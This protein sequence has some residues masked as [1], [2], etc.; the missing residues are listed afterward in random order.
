MS[1]YFVHLYLKR[2]HCL[3]KLSHRIPYLPYMRVVFLL[4]CVLI[5][6][7]AIAQPKDT[8]HCDC[9][10]A[11]NIPIYKK[12]HHIAPKGYGAIIEFERNGMHNG[13]YFDKEHNTVWYSFTVPNEG[14]L[15]FD[16]I[17]DTVKDDY[18]FILF[19][20]WGPGACDS[21]KSKKLVPVRANISHNGPGTKSLTGMSAAGRFDYNPPGA[22]DNYSKALKVNSGER[23]ILVVDNVY[24]NGKGHTLKFYFDFKLRGIVQDSSSGKPLTATI[25]LK[26]LK[27]GN[28]MTKTKCDSM[29]KGFFEMPITIDDTLIWSLNFSAPGYFSENMVITQ[30]NLTAFLQR[31]RVY[32]LRKIEKNKSF[33]LKDIN[34]FPNKDILRPTSLPTLQNLLNVMKDN[35]GLKIL[36]EGHTNFDPTVTK[37][38]DI[39]LSERRALAVKKYLQDN[40]IDPTRISTHGSGSTRMVYPNPRTQD[41]QQANMR[42][43]IKIEEF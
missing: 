25:I 42:V 4:S 13:K 41:Q 38:W 18:D 12:H 39:Q 26:E 27:T 30:N 24:E 14:I 16:L 5:G 19:R 32:K 9:P 36:I 35:P 34:F 3:C 8:I 20:N 6:V 33:A 23:Y 28:E 2:L 31:T 22:H 43:E 10:K 1:C 21:I 40:G 29:N 37:A 15:T 7:C 17:P 11:L